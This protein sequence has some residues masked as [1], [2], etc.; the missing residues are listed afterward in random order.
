[1]DRSLD[2]ILEERQVRQ[3]Q[4]CYINSILT[5]DRALAADAAEDVAVLIAMVAVD[6]DE[7]SPNASATILEMASKRSV[8]LETHGLSRHMLTVDACRFSFLPRASVNRTTSIN[9]RRQN[10]TPSSIR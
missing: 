6:P 5:C 2:E 10:T 4:H 3:D 1:M 9:M 8:Y 7:T